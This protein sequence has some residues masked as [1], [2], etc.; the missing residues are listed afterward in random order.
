MPEYFEFNSIEMS[1][2]LVWIKLLNLPLKCWSSNCL[3][4]IASVLGKPIQFDLLTSSMTRL[5]NARILVEVDLLGDLPKSI[6][7]CLPNGV[8]CISYSTGGLLDLAEIL[9]TLLCSWS[10]D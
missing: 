5:S 6:V 1:T 9:Q 10:L 2:V 8:W 7:V 4:K 3:S